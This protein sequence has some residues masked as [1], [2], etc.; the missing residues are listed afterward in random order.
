M[1]YTLSTITFGSGDGKSTIFAR[2]YAPA[3]REIRGVVQLAHGMVDH[4][5][6]YEAL[7]DA[8]TAEGYVLA[9][10][11]HLGHGNSVS[12]GGEFGFFADR[13]GVKCVLHDLH[14]MNRFLREKF[15]VH[16][17]VILGHSMGSFL[18]RLYVEKYPHTVAGHIIHGTGGPLGV[19]LPLGKG[20]VRAMSLFRGKHYR[21]PFVKSISF[22]G[23]NSKFP[24]SDGKNAWLTREQALVKDRE[25]DPRTSF[26]FTLSAYHDLF[27][28]VGD[29]N[30]KKWF[31]SY[32]TELPTLIMS[33]DMDPVGNYGDGPKY[34][35]KH[36]LMRGVSNLELK[37][38]PGARH[39][40]FNESCRDEVFRDIT[41]WLSSI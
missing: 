7:A 6:R 19:I 24:K 8:L 16:K 41:N 15:P 22:M 32:Q 2:I 11:D 4:T 29:S 21:S 17:P 9:G 1:N 33:G 26:I 30:S 20:L 25:G 37:L 28:M 12:A 18:S 5:G 39:E 27:T 38:Y 3:D 14:V 31:D 10:N 35:Y 36:L 40:L 23:Y 13:D 34:V